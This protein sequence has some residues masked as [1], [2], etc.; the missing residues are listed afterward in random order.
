M[1]CLVIICKF[2]IGMLL[3]TWSRQETWNLFNTYVLWP[4][5]IVTIHVRPVFTQEVKNIIHFF[6]FQWEFTDTAYSWGYLGVRDFKSALFLEI[7]LHSLSP[8]HIM[9]LLF[10]GPR[11][12]HSINTDAAGNISPSSWVAEELDVFSCKVNTLVLKEF[13]L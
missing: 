8:L 11:S 3:T 13:F 4:L 12:Y 10:N 2:R 6:L 5:Q 1:N 9:R 7:I